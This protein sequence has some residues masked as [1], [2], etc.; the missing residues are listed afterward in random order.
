MI[1]HNKE[2]ILGIDPGTAIVG[3][4]LIEKEGK[5][6]RLL[7]YSCIRTHSSKKLSERLLEIFDQINSII[8]KYKPDTVVIEQLFFFKN[9]KTA[10]SV[11]QARGVLMLAAQINKK[12]FFEYT[13][14]Q[15]KKAMSGYGRAEK[16]QIQDMVKASLG[17]EEI[18]KPDDAADALAIA[19]CHAQ[20]NQKL[21]Y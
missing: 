15:V 16:K 18:P 9:T 10:M 11:G 2:I 3:W 13:P 21:R 8:K 1:N 20:T 7:D 4:G 5:K 14:L 17:L 6:C 19:L 12:E